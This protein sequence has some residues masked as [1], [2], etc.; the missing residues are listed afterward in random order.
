MSR[1]TELLV[2]VISCLEVELVAISSWDFVLVDT[3]LSATKFSSD[4]VLF[5]FTSG[6]SG[7][8]SDTLNVNLHFGHLIVFLS[9][10]VMVIVLAHFRHMTLVELVDTSSS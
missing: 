1:L 3:V 10:S 6:K 2:C 4:F 9:G 5:I 7:F 8:R